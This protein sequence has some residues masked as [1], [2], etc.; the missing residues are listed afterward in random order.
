VSRRRRDDRANADARGGRV[1][2]GF[3]VLVLVASCTEAPAWL[4]VPKEV[5]LEAKPEPAPREVRRSP[6]DGAL[7]WLDTLA[8]PLGHQGE[9]PVDPDPYLNEPGFGPVVGDAPRPYAGERRELLV[10]LS[11]HSRIR[12]GD[13]LTLGLE[14]ESRADATFLVLP[15]V[16]GSFA[17]L[18]SPVYQIYLEEKASGR[19]YRYYL[20]V[21]CGNYA[22]FPSAASFAVQPGVRRKLTENHDRDDA[23]REVTLD[24]AGRYAVWVVYAVCDDPPPAD[25]VRANDA[26]LRGVFSS[27]AIEVT[28][29][30]S[31][32][33]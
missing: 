21:E 9:W 7:P 2:V 20:P 22:D 11:G 8:P 18:S 32:E 17:T 12:A 28:V 3:T 4:Q 30:E 31:S 5:A 19:V 24:K 16:Q 25:E 26:L 1:L 10:H 23:L 27:N 29:E 15:P 13:A 6:C 33:R 14:F